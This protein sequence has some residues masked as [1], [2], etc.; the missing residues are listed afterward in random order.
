[1]R[2]REQDE[3][4]TEEKKKKE[5]VREVQEIFNSYTVSSVPLNTQ[6]AAP[7]MIQKT[8]LPKC[9]G[10]KRALQHEDSNCRAK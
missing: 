9:T 6:M 1:M 7:T 10:R 5:N 4:K 3:Q 2:K 8:T